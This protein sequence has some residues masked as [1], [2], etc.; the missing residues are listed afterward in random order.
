VYDLLSRRLKIRHD[1]L[2]WKTGCPFFYLN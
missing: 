2:H 1:V